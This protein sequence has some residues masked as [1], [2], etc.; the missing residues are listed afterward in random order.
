MVAIN[1]ALERPDLVCK[2][3]ADS[4]E[5]EVPLQEFVQSVEEVRETS[6][7]DKYVR[8]FYYLMHGDDWESVVDNDTFA[9]REHAKTI[10][11]FF[12]KAL[13]ELQ[14]EISFTG[15]KEDEFIKFVDPDF[16]LKTFSKLIEKVGN[17][18]MH[19]FEQGGHPALLSNKDEFVKLTKDFFK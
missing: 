1:V 18:K 13:N 19:I 15:S 14:T 9:I 8:S 16:Y 11:R 10:G 17:G 6:K 3:I 2:V 12:H 7:Q 4:F 5:G